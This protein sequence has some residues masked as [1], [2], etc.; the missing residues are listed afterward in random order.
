VKARDAHSAEC[1]TLHTL[2]LQATRGTP[3]AV[4]NL[5]LAKFQVNQDK[6]RKMAL[7]MLMGQVR[8][9]ST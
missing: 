8:P 6:D 7:D 2:S 9:V 1:T 4:S 3:E 5:A